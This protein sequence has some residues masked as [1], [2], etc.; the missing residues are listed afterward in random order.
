MAELVTAFSILATRAPVVVA[1][2]REATRLEELGVDGDSTLRRRLLEL[3]KA[4]RRVSGLVTGVPT[5]RN[6][7]AAVHGRRGCL[8]QSGRRAVVIAA[9]RSEEP[10]LV[11]PLGG[12]VMVPS[13]SSSAAASVAR[14]DSAVSGALMTTIDDGDVEMATSSSLSTTA[15]GHGIE[16]E[17]DSGVVPSVARRDALLFAPLTSS[18]FAAADFSSSM[19]SIFSSFSFAAAR[20]RSLGSLPAFAG[21][22][23]AGSTLSSALAAATAATAR[24]ATSSGGGGSSSSGSTTSRQV[25]RGPHFPLMSQVHGAPIFRHNNSSGIVRAPV[26]SPSASS[27]GSALL[28]AAA[29]VAARYSFFL[30]VITIILIISWN[31]NFVHAIDCCSIRCCCSFCAAFGR[32]VVLFEQRSAAR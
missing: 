1:T 32:S 28:T 19:Q 5:G 18:S 16:E 21:A 27:T 29:A 8:Q 23:L 2:T 17:K 25:Q 26:S 7:Y 22:G 31:F 12:R 13:S 4:L 20:V 11:A 30:I 9:R 15:V 14:F 24:A 3:S 6:P 10:S